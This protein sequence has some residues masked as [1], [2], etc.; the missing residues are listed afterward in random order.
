MLT[1]L[2]SDYAIHGII[3]SFGI[4]LYCDTENN[5]MQKQKWL[6]QCCLGCDVKFAT[7]HEV[8]SMTVSVIFSLFL[9]LC[10]SLR[11]QEGHNQLEAIVIVIVFDF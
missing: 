6:S 2:F 7:P 10:F 5:S 8:N 11:V 9:L 1:V 3:T 4:Q